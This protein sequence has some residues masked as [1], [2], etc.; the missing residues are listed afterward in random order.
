MN[1]LHFADIVGLLGIKCVS[2]NPREGI[3]CFLEE[4]GLGFQVVEGLLVL[5]VKLLPEIRVSVRSYLQI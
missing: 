1:V 4:P 5:V 3:E 2:Q